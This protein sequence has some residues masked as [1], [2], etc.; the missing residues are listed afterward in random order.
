MAEETKKLYM[1]MQMDELKASLMDEDD[2]LD[3]IEQMQKEQVPSEKKVNK[4]NKKNNEKNIELAKMYEDAAEYE[5]ELESFEAELAVIN[6]NKL[7]DIVLALTKELPNEE[8]DYA[9]E[10]KA[11][12]VAAWTYKVETE[13]TH[14]QAQLD[15]IKDTEFCDV[16]E[17]LTTMDPDYEGDFAADVRSV[18]VK[19]LEMLIAIKKEHIEQEIEE[20]YIAGLKPSFVKR[21][22]KQVHG[23]S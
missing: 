1:E 21:I 17:K 11:I 9:Q 19:R 8:R 7:E 18:L 6:A 3:P 14:S 20:I 22:Y 13:K 10:L 5:E 12:L 2:E 4:N 23:L 15:L 16:I